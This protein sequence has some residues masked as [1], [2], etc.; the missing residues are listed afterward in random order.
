MDISVTT[1]KSGTNFPLTP[2]GMRRMELRSCA[3]NDDSLDVTTTMFITPAM[4]ETYELKCE[5][6]RGMRQARND[7]LKRE[8]G[9]D[10][11]TV[12]WR[13]EAFVFLDEPSS[14]P[15]IP[16]GERVIT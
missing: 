16:R 8:R 1:V 15:S 9:I 7:M 6:I 11:A 14:N 3:A 2:A 12:T 13:E 5:V 10:G 4:L